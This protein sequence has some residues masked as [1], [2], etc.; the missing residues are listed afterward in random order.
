[1]TVLR[2]YEREGR[3]EPDPQEVCL[4]GGVRA[5]VRRPRDFQR[6]PILSRS[7]PAH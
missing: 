2:L 4:Q 1:M 7:Y 5:V 3:P 6:R